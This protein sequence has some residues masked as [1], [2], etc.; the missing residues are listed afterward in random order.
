MPQSHVVVIGGGVIG[1][2]TAYY[3]AQHRQRVTLIEQNQLSSGASY[4]H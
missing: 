4:E 2:C 1:V 3:L